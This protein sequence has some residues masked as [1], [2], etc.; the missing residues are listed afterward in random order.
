M[1]RPFPYFYSEY[2]D[3]ACER[4]RADTALNGVNYERNPTEVG[5]WERISITSEEGSRSIGR[6]IGIYNTLFTSRMYELDPTA[7]ECIAI[8]ISDE[9]K[10]I[11]NIMKVKA[12]RVLVVGL[13][14][15]ALTPDAVGP[16]CA[17]AVNATMQIKR[18]DKKSFDAL[19]C[20]EIAVIKP[21]VSAESGLD[22]AETVLSVC[23]GISPDLVI[24]ID[25]LAAGASD[26]L[27]STVQISSTGILPGSGL[28][29]NSG[30]IN[31][32]TLSVPVIAI[33]VPTV[34]DSR[35]FAGSKATDDECSPMFVSPKD[36]HLVVECSA[37][38]IG[39]AINK[40][41]G[42]EL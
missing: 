2:S 6:P 27:G 34:M 38:I 18:I 40:A 37:K 30:A 16:E 17:D 25:A 11:T 14:N 12:H 13:G 7:T 33:G 28:G 4:R 29:I 32:E 36:V 3:L 21:G 42:I 23:R 26:R 8:E 5:I 24:A 22:A 41:F 31:E 39:G 1:E 20:C 15:A 10:S 9:L 19:G 35:I